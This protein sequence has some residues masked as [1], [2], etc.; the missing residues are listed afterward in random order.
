MAQGTPAM[1]DTPG[2]QKECVTS[3]NHTSGLIVHSCLSS[4]KTHSDI[5]L[6]KKEDKE[7]HKTG[8]C[9]PRHSF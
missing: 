5:V 9:P 4:N 3:S 1:Q 6:P 7:I 8:L 2:A